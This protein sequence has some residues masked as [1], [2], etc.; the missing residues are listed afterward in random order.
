MPRRKFVITASINVVC[1]TVITVF[2][3]VVVF[4]PLERNEKAFAG[5]MDT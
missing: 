5:H 4:V 2:V 3:A 1:V